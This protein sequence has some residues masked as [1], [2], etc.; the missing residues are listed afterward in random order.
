MTVPTRH[1]IR[2]EVKGADLTPETMP[3]AKLIEVLGLLERA[4]VAFARSQGIKP[5]DSGFVSLTS[6]FE[7]SAGLEVST[8]APLLPP[9]RSVTR[10]IESGTTQQLPRSVQDPLH[11]LSQVVAK[12]GWSFASRED[13]KLEIPLAVISAARPVPKPEELPPLEGSTTIFAR[14]VKVGGRDPKAELEIPRSPKLLN[15]ELDERVARALGGFLYDWVV[16]EGTARWNPET[17]KMESFRAH[18]VSPYR[19]TPVDLAFQE[20]RKAAAGELDGLDAVGFVRSL[21]ED[22]A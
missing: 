11:E 3:L 19:S 16:V 18:R 21:R 13:R 12:Q 14:C 4:V 10:A 20:L 6:V 22:R 5:E 1:K 15:V 17:L 2:F 9:V 7:S 8:P